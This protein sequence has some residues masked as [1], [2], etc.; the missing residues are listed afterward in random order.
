[1]TSFSFKFFLYYI[2][3][4]FDLINRTGLFKKKRVK[5]KKNQDITLKEYE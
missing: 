5:Q 2:N 3:L 1:M 4:V